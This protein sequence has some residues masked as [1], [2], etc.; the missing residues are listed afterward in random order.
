MS[1]YTV[2]CCS[3]QY[4]IYKNTEGEARDSFF[5]YSVRIKLSKILYVG[6]LPYNELAY[7]WK[8]HLSYYMNARI[9]LSGDKVNQEEKLSR[10]VFPDSLEQ[11]QWKWCDDGDCLAG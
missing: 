7:F 11:T 8:Y 2:F 6:T 4:I 1:Q 9:L 10:I 5:L 3:F